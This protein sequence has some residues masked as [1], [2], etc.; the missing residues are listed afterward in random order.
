M[1]AEIKI[2]LKKESYR[3]YGIL[4]PACSGKTTLFQSMKKQSLKLKK[5][6]RL[7][8]M[9]IDEVTFDKD[10]SDRILSET[11][12]K[13]ILFPHLRN[14]VSQALAKY[15]KYRIII[16]SSNAE[17]FK[18][19]RI[20]EN[21]IRIFVQALPLFLQAISPLLNTKHRPDESSEDSDGVDTSI[22]GS[23]EPSLVKSNS[24]VTSDVR[25][26]VAQSGVLTS[27]GRI[28]D[29]RNSLS[30]QLQRRGSAK[31]SSHLFNSHSTMTLPGR[32]ASQLAS[33]T[34]HIV[35]ITNE[36]GSESVPITFEDELLNICKS[37]DRIMAD[38]KD[39]YQMYDT[40]DHLFDLVVQEFN[41]QLK[42]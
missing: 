4:L 19:L 20:H 3:L 38:F 22:L 24:I 26:R 39:K 9:D 31:S 7:I 23:D 5:G 17:F 30:N 8:L 21:K 18:Y 29:S 41:I 28:D 16:I 6:T 32:L 40:F 37:R 2:N 33:L 13:E 12:S 10:E 15:P 34:G 1:S 25:S 42:E 11:S 35:T 27:S 36:E 14:V